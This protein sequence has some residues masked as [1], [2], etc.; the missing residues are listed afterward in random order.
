M[1]NKD[2]I[3][4]E[5]PQLLTTKEIASWLGISPERVYSL[6]SSQEFPNIKISYMAKIFSAATNL[7]STIYAKDQINSRVCPF[8]VGVVWCG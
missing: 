1:T 8:R 7:H 2:D 3:R 6:C 5:L 4:I